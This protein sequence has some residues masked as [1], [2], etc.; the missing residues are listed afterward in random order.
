MAKRI[1][2][3]RYYGEGNENNQPK[4]LKNDDGQLE[5][6]TLEHFQ[7]SGRTG[8]RVFQDYLP[9]TKIGIQTLPNTK[10]YLNNSLDGYIII[11]PTGVYELNLEGISEIGDLGFD[12][13][14]L[15]LIRDNPNGYLIIDV[16][17]DS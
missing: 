11:G 5:T 9:F 1:M 15:E 12:R 8:G 14:S 10:F 13:K 3:F 16:I 2:Q 17:Y 6:V 7:T 4:Q